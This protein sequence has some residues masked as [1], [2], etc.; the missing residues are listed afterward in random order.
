MSDAPAKENLTAHRLLAGQLAA[1]REARDPSKDK[2]P[3]SEGESWSESVTELT[4]AESRSEVARAALRRRLEDQTARALWRHQPGEEPN[5]A[6]RI[7]TVAA[8]A[9]IEPKDALEEMIAAQMLAVHEAAME[10][11]QLARGFRTALNGTKYPE[12]HVAY[13]CQAGKLCR[14]F[15]MLLD[16][17]N[18]HRGKGQQKITVEHVHVHPGGQ[19][20]VGIVEAPGG[21][22][23]PKSGSRSY[24]P[25]NADASPPLPS[26]RGEDEA[27]DAMPIASDA[28]RPVPDTRREGRCSER[29][30]E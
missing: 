8:I 16:A 12:T 20:V 1:R 14:T 28:E 30:H 9:A 13:F 24:E 27:R 18:R 6:Q 7:L 23:K 5:D 21:G 4:D 25:G 19:A 29:Q 10:S 2:A 15:A 11:F 26:L 17:L 22:V 3:M